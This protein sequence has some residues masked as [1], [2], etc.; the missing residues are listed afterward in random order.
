MGGFFLSSSVSHV[1]NLGS[2]TRRLIA[3]ALR[4]KKPVALAI[5]V[6]CPHVRNVK[7]R[8]ADD[9]TLLL[10]GLQ[11]LEAVELVYH[12]GSI[13]SPGPHTQTFLGVR[14]AGLTSIALICNTMSLVMLDTIAQCCPGLA[15]LWSR[16]NHLL[17]PYEVEGVNMNHNYL[18]NLHTLYLRVGEGELSVTSIPEYVLPFL[19]RN[20]GSGLKE[21]IVAVRSNVINDSYIYNLVCDNELFGLQKILLVVPGLNSLPGIL[22][23]KAQTVHNLLH[24]CPQL[25]KLGNLLSWDVDKEEAGEIQQTLAGMNYDLQIVN[26]KM[27]MR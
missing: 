14:G 19:V 16:S 24:L 1:D 18:T 22:K 26:K 15:Q 23:L 8:V 13:G 5:S 17:A 11:H 7:L 20:A 2:K 4:C 10:G 12:V 27:T 25:G 3:S 21:L 9:D 6:L